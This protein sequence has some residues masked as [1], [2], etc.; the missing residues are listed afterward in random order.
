MSYDRKPI[1]QGMKVYQVGTDQ[2]GMPLVQSYEV[3]DINDSGNVAVQYWQTQN[4]FPNRFEEFIPA[5]KLHTDIKALID[6]HIEN[7]S[8]ILE[9]LPR[10]IERW[11]KL[12]HEFSS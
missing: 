9:R 5:N 4:G 7:D 3:L 2:D 1:H 12:K 10:R 8:K 6:M 11:N